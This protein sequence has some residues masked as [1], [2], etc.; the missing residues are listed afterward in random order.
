VARPAR[1][2]AR[3]SAR[4]C[5]GSAREDTRPAIP[6]H[7]RTRR[8]NVVAIIASALVLAVVAVSLLVAGGMWPGGG[9]RTRYSDP[10]TTSSVSAVGRPALEES[11]SDL[12]AKSDPVSL[13]GGA[14]QSG[15]S[16]SSPAPS[17]GLP[18]V[19][20]VPAGTLSH[21]ADTTGTVPQ[22]YLVVGNVLGWANR[23]GGVVCVTC[24]SATLLGPI[25]PATGVPA[26]K[27][28]AGTRD[29]SPEFVGVSLVAATSGRARTD[30]RP[31]VRTLHII[32]L[33]TAGGATFVVDR[34]VR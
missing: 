24:V 2:G 16:S 34:V 3:A 31:G 21:L 10:L 19:R 29:H 14:G 22:T 1:S 12:S 13:A 28:P 17:G 6:E 18:D 25:D 11:S 9:A 5:G 23:A 15:T 8:P 27:P 4:A 32:L 7:R 33:P 20:D 30:L 26:G